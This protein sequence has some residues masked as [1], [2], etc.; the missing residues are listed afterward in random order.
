MPSL[1]FGDAWPWLQWVI[2]VAAVVAFLGAAIR[3][4][5]AVWRS[6]KRFI[7]TVD[8]LADLPEELVSQKQFREETT[9]TLASQD[10]K[11]AEIHH[12]VNF[13]NG[14]SVKDSITRVEASV[15]ALRKDVDELVKKDSSES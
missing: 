13:N 11:I 12:E 3:V 15:T 7:Q 6:V 2:A 10:T 4:V 5:P 9:Q 1:N 8:S 14:S